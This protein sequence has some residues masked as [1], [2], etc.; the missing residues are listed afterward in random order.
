[1]QA[2]L[3]QRE[4]ASADDLKQS[5]QQIG[6]A[7][8]RA[9]HTVNQLLALARAE[10]GGAVME[11]QPC[12]LAQLT[13]D[14]VREAVPQAMD[15]QI[16]LGYDGPAP[17][18]PE[19]TLLGNPTL[20]REMIRNLVE[21]AIHYTPST[22]ESPGVVTAR[23]RV[24][25]FSRALA[26]QV[27]DNGPGIPQAERASV[28]QPFY[29]ALGTNV[30]GSGLGLPIVQEIAAQHRAEVSVDDAHPGQQPPGACFTVRFRAS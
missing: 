24:E 15:K 7:S 30:H 5:L 8:V 9:T 6:H 23:L 29:R 20:L 25:P 28:F 19:L 17:G 27:E 12:D 10:A 22:P 1:M 26:V 4:D 18:A 11:Q 21:N 16:D 14:V 13:I 3:A 2:D